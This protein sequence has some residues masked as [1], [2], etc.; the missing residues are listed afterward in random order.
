MNNKRGVSA[1]SHVMW[2]T[3]GPCSGGSNDYPFL[4][5]EDTRYGGLGDMLNIHVN[6]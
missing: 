2:D 5:L 4:L 3:T 6:K 1:C